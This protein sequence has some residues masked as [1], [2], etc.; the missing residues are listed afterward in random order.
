MPI[1]I[2]L[3]RI[4]PYRAVSES[5][6]IVA[7]SSGR[8]ASARTVHLI[9]GSRILRPGHRRHKVRNAFGDH[10]GVVSV[11]ASRTAQGVARRRN[12]IGKN[13]SVI[14]LRTLRGAA[15]LASPLPVTV[16]VGEPVIAVAELD[17]D[18][19]SA[20]LAI[21]SPLSDLAYLI[22]LTVRLYLTRRS[23]ALSASQGS[24]ALIV[25]KVRVVADRLVEIRNVAFI[26]VAHV[27]D[28]EN[29]LIS[30]HTEI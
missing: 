16:L 3:G 24:V 18:R 7:D 11:S 19:I 29:P 21:G 23:S 6:G 17:L 20:L 30:V 4:T 1:G 26:C 22:G 5:V 15:D 12:I 28:R 2:L 10:L 27:R 14:G 25:G 8:R 13:Y 9:I